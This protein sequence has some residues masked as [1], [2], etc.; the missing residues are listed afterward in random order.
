[1]LQKEFKENAAAHAVFES[2]ANRERARDQVT[3]HSL[4]QKMRKEGHHFSSVEYSDLLRKLSKAGVG[5]LET[6]RTGRVKA[7]K[8]I[9]LT[10]Q[11]LGRAAVGMSSRLDRFTK[12]RQYSELVAAA[13]EIKE[14]SIEFPVSLT[15]VINGKPVNF[16]VP[17]NLSPDEIATLV[18]RFQG[19]L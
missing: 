3:V 5:R 13:K 1:M 7:L 4:A 19:A 14:H 9:K 10:L 8:D 17:S 11:S 15:V 6:S 18:K 12:Q 2:W 16:R